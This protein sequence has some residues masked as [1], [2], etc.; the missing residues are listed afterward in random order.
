MSARQHPILFFGSIHTMRQR[1][2]SDADMLSPEAL[3]SR[4]IPTP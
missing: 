2:E 1:A 4:G 3:I